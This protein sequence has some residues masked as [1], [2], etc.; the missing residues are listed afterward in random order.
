[1]SNVIPF[2]KAPKPAKG[3]QGDPFDNFE[4]EIQEILEYS[5][6]ECMTALYDYDIYFDTDEDMKMVAMYIETTKALIMKGIGVNHPMHEIAR[7]CFVAEDDGITLS[8]RFTM[9]KETE[10]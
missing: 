10:E 9:G 4:S 8:Y 6:S 2:P 7:A 1:M 3:D 5:V